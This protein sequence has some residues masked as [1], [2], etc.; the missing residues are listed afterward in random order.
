M[1]S[2]TWVIIDL[3]HML[4]RSRFV[5]RGASIADAVGLSLHI[6]INSIKQASKKYKADHIVIA[7]EGR[8]WRKEYDDSYKLNRTIKRENATPKE[9]EEN[10]GSFFLGQNNMR[11]DSL[12]DRERSK[13]EEE[14]ER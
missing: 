3:A 7:A 13:R 10:D 12:R 8:S 11:Q 5:S 2:K 9:K 14:R 4:N 1:T 6:A